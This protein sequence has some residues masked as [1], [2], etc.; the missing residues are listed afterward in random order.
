M[1]LRGGLWGDWGWSVVM[2]ENKVGA[3]EQYGILEWRSV[4]ED[5]RQ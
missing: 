5:R 1:D 2:E 3:R 4:S